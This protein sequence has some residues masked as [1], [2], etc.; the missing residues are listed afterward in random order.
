MSR[1]KDIN[2]VCNQTNYTRD[3]AVK[4]LEEHD[5]DPII[6]IKKYLGITE[7]PKPLSK[8][9]SQERYK[10]IREHLDENYKIYRDSK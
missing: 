4:Q 10:M 8:T 7:K 9:L 2:T 3:E 1:E 6:V 5:N